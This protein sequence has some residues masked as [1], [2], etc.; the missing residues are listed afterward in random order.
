MWQCVLCIQYCCF[1]YY[2]KVKDQYTRWILT[3]LS[4]LSLAKSD[5]VTGGGSN[6]GTDT[7]SVS[8]HVVVCM[9]SDV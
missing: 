1:H 3:V 5:G 7:S 4:T 8:E 2:L 6:D 9:S